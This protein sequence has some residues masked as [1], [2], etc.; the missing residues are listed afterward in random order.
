MSYWEARK[1]REAYELYVDVEKSA[2]ELARIYAEASEEISRDA[3][4]LIRKFRLRHNLTERE[5]RIVLSGVDSSEYRRI[6]NRIRTVNADFAAELEAPSFAQDLN[7]LKALQTHVDTVT[8]SI[9][10]ASAPIFVK[11][12]EK[13]AKE[14]Y[15][16]SIFDMQQQSGYGFLFNPLTEDKISEILS[17]KW[18]GENYS[19]RIWQNTEALAESVKRELVK[20]MLTGKSPF[21]MSQ[22]INDRFHASSTNSRRLM[23]TEANYVANQVTLMSYTEAGVERYIYV[24]VLDLRTSEI[25]R[26]LDRKRFLVKN[27]MVGEN[28]PPMHPWCR[29]TTIAWMPDYLLREL[30]QRA[31]DPKTGEKVLVP[32]SMNYEEWYRRFVLDEVQGNNAVR[33]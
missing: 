3:R 2:D 20:G 31:L 12:L 1:A 32:M 5:A 24:A 25:C 27:A 10:T 11:T 7:R 26:S 30:Q 16:H 4:R 19:Q 22:T 13:V 28:Y 6:I 8:R 9:A 15:Y 21:R 29:S 18:S 14:A 23:R 17:R 33:G